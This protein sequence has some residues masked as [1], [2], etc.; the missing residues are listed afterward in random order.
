MPP[1]GGGD[2]DLPR[3]LDIHGAALGLDHGLGDGRDAALVT[4]QS[5]RG[6]VVVPVRPNLMPDPRDK[7]LQVYNRPFQFVILNPEGAPGE[8]LDAGSLQGRFGPPDA[9]FPCGRR[10]VRVYLRPEAKAFREQFMGMPHFMRLEKPGDRFELH[11]IW[12]PSENGWIQGNGRMAVSPQS[13]AGRLIAGLGV[14]LPVGRYL[15]RIHFQAQGDG[16][17]SPGHWSLIREAKGERREDRVADFPMTGAGSVVGLLSVSEGVR[18]D[19]N[20]VFHGNGMLLVTGIE[21]E[22]PLQV[23]Q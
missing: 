10:L 20:V 1:R 5:Q 23:I 19:L 21:L 4:G 17:Q 22:I 14:D 8:R 13:S 15:Y 11:P 18:S 6:M 9:E 3:C 12:M 2:N 7:G 16:G